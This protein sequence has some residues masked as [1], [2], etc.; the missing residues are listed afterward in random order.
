M[1]LARTNAGLAEPDH[2]GER[3]SCPGC[4]E[5]VVG[6][7]GEQV[8]WHWSHLARAD[9][10]TWYEPMTDWHKQWQLSAPTYRREVPMGGHRADIVTA[11]GRIYEIQHSA[12]SADDVHDREEF[13]RGD[14]VWIWDCQEAF[15]E[16]RIAY[17]FARERERQTE[18]IDRR[19]VK[20]HWPQSRRTIGLCTRVVL[21]DLGRWVLGVD[22]H[23]DTMSWGMGHLWEPDVVRWRLGTEHPVERRLPICADAAA[24]ARLT[25]LAEP[26]PR[27][28]HPE[29]CCICKS[30]TMKMNPFGQPQCDQCATYATARELT[31]CG[32]CGLPLLYEDAA[33]DGCH[34]TCLPEDA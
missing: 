9:C 18:R 7:C 6:K 19:A 27:R 32:A 11:D 34:A 13:Y 31:E 16:G 33:I 24:R 29:L 30:S 25:S 12:L 15:A 17:Q 8:V 22:R 2:S 10:D 5:H 21:L 28:R 20:F 1:L 4:G 23:N 14:L 26:A 3:A